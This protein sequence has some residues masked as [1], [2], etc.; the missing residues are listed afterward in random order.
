MFYIAY[1]D[2]GSFHAGAPS[3]PLHRLVITPNETVGRQIAKKLS[4]SNTMGRKNPRIL[5]AWADDEVIL[6]THPDDIGRQVG[7]S[8]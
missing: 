8:R 2:H 1:E 7:D 4:D 5:G 3:G 6:L